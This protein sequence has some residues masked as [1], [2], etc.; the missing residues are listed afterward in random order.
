MDPESYKQVVS[1]V[2]NDYT[3]VE[4]IG[5]TLRDAKTGWLNDWRT[6]LF[7]GND[8]Y[9]SRIYEDLELVD[10]VGGGD[11]FAAGLIY[12]LLQ[13]KSPQEAVDFA[14]AY[15]AIAHTFPGDFNL[16]LIHI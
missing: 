10:R 13:D 4:K 12:S 3:N 11:S 14:G 1:R 8:F 16:S 5:T 7:D 6:L 9:L 2:I 15:S